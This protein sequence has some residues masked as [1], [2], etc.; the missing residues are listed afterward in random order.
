[1]KRILLT[2]LIFL[3]TISAQA[4]QDCVITSDG[5]LTDISIEDN[6]VV[7]VYP[8]VTVLNT[9]NILILH[10]L[11]EGQTRVCVLKNGKEKIMFG[12]TVNSENTEIEEVNGIESF[13]LDVPEFPQPEEDTFLDLPPVLPEKTFTPKLRGEE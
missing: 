13:T 9:K 2:L 4:F 8:L 3:S 11:K 7:N 1:M 6:T 12:V 5:K 10:P